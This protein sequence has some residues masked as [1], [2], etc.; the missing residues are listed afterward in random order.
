MTFITDPGFIRPIQTIWRNRPAPKPAQ[1]EEDEEIPWHVRFWQ[2]F[3]QL[4]IR[5]FDRFPQA[6]DF[7]LAESRILEAKLCPG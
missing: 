5:V 7:F 2:D 3:D 6:C 4:L 1:P